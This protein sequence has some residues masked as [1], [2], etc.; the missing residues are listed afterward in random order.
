MRAAPVRSCRRDPGA[1]SAP[2]FILLGSARG[3]SRKRSVG[4]VRMLLQSMPPSSASSRLLLLLALACDRKDDAQP[5]PTE[6]APVVG[7][8]AQAIDA[9]VVAAPQSTPSE[10]EAPKV[11]A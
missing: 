10:P 7:Q 6:P 8:T 1:G 9:P 3:G 4:L 5:L 11:D 2:C